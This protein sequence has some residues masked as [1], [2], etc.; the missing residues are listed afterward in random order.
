[1]YDVTLKI[2]KILMN[3]RVETILLFIILIKFLMCIYVIKYD[4]QNKV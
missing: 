2:V 3:E 4:Q 1:M